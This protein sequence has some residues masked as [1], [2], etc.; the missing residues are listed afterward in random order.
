[1]IARALK[2]LKSH[3]TPPNAL[4]A[5]TVRLTVRSV[6]RFSYS[7]SLR[8]PNSTKTISNESDQNTGSNLDV[9]RL[10]CTSGKDFLSKTKTVR[11]TNILGRCLGN[12][13]HNQE[14]S[15]LQIARHTEL[16]LD[17]DSV[18]LQNSSVYVRLSMLTND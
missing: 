16:L 18:H 15:T 17:Q 5:E 13:T 6:P 8:R 3:K 9:S 7:T 12:E 10:Q 14:L 1:V 11:N 4:Y 2:H